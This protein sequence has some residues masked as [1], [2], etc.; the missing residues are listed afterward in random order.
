M[1]LDKQILKQLEKES[2][3]LYEVLLEML[4]AIKEAIEKL[5]KAKSPD[6]K[7]AISSYITCY[8]HA[9]GLRMLLVTLHGSMTEDEQL[10]RELKRE[11]DYLDGV[12]KANRLGVTYT[13]MQGYEFH[14][15][16]LREKIPEMSKY[17]RINSRF[18][19]MPICS[20]ALS[21]KSETR[22]YDSSP[23]KV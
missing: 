14:Q 3:R 6:L 23:E 18:A 20:L 17:Q 8:V 19:G 7:E 11:E 12:I 15:K 16:W 13:C 1:G 2:K 9:R 5:K 22:T 21:D 4:K 10:E